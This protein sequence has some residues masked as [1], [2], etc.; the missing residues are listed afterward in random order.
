MHYTYRRQPERVGLF[1]TSAA[2]I[3]R[4]LFLAE[5]GFD[6]H[7]AGASIT[8]DIELGQ[9][10][11]SRGY[12]IVMDQRLTVMHDKH[13]T[14]G[15]LLRTD[16]RRARG[17][18]QT[19]VRNRL[20]Q[21]KRAHYASV[22]WFFGAGVLMMGLGTLLAL[23][24]LLFWSG[25]LLIAAILTIPLALLFNAPFLAALGRWR[26]LRFFA[27]SAGFLVLDLYASGLGVAW[28][29]ADCARG[30]AY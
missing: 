16:L 6:A 14:V 23:L 19:W 15:E 5:G 1:Y 25:P 28:G 17:L 11:L 2:S 22:P 3:R 21:T 20:Q 9:R 4:E 12:R 10:L 13:Y 30:R 18:M 27:L 26:G 29:I 7:Y 8:E 24:A